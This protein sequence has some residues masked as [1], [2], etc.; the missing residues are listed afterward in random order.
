M[1]FSLIWFVL[2]IA[3]LL[4]STQ[5]IVKLAES[6]SQAIKISPLIIGTTVVALGTS[7][8]ELAVSTIAVLRGDVGLALGNIIGS[9]I[10]NI[11]MVLPAGILIG[12]LRIGT[13]KTQRNSLIVLAATVFFVLLQLLNI[14]PLI[15]GLLLLGSAVL[16]TASEFELGILGRKHEDMTQFNRSQREDFDTAKILWAV[17][18][19]IGIIAGG[20]LVVA[21]I[22]KISVL[23]GYSTTILGLTLTAAA[24]SLPELAA[25]IIAQEEHQEKITIGNIIGSNI[26]NLLFI[27]GIATLFSGFIVTSKFSW[28]WLILTTAFFVFILRYFSGKV[29]PK[30]VG[31][32]LLSFL[33]VYIMI[34]GIK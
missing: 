23:T 17:L 26:Y 33:A 14:S 34:M 24:T 27:G 11:L 32:I 31:W 13:T 18:S 15:S 28:T 22:E 12:K 3:V 16:V 9:N 4:W 30:R 1:L 8:P 29:V 19:I 2:G 25:T 21:T 7:L 6:F 10:V 5:K 20:V